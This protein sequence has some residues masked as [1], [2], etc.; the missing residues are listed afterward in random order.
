MKPLRGN[1][2]LPMR[3][4]MLLSWLVIC[5]QAQG[6]RGLSEEPHGMKKQSRFH[7]YCG[8]A[9]EYGANAFKLAYYVLKFL[10]E[11]TNYR[12]QPL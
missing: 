12:A 2:M 1:T 8:L 9:L 5:V 4:I 7:H 10:G 11:V 3:D 6:S